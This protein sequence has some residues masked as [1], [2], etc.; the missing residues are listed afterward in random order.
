MAI[1]NYDHEARNRAYRNAVETA[2]AEF[3]AL[4]PEYRRMTA[5]LVQLRRLI[6]AGAELLGEEVEAEFDW[7]SY[8]TP[9]Q[10]SPRFSRPGGGGRGAIDRPATPVKPSLGQPRGPDGA[11]GAVGSYSTPTPSVSRV[12]HP[13]DEEP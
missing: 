1:D 13:P 9:R 4:Q 6:N 3:R 10:P 12:I 8:P 5:Q 11:S 2:K 7:K